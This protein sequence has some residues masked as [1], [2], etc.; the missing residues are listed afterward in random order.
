MEKKVLFDKAKVL[1]DLMTEYRKTASLK[2][3]DMNEKKTLVEVYNQIHPGVRVDLGCQGCVLSYMNTITSW[4]GREYPLYLKEPEIKQQPIKTDKMKN[5][6]DL[7]GGAQKIPATETTIDLSTGKKT[8][9][10]I[11]GVIKTDSIDDSNVITGTKPE[12]AKVV[13]PEHKETAEEKVNPSTPIPKT[14]IKK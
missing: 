1:V 14:E 12:D 2:F 3:K 11:P 8:E 6:I 10:K 13:K 4:Y 9:T 7:S 5:E